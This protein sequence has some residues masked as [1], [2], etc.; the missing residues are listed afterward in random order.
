MTQSRF[1]SSTFS[2]VRKWHPQMYPPTSGVEGNGLQKLKGCSLIIQPRSGTQNQHAPMSTWSY[3]WHI[4]FRGHPQNGGFPRG[5][6]S[7]QQNRDTLKTRHTLSGIFAFGGRP[8]LVLEPTLG[9]TQ[10]EGEG[11]VLPETLQLVEHREVP[12]FGVAG[13]PGQRSAH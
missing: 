6:P 13:V 2:E 10:L 12:R 5:V 4:F 7:K 3:K 1:T 11:P 8:D 9:P